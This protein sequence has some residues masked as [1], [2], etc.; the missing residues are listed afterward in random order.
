[1]ETVFSH[2]GRHWFWF[3]PRPRGL[4]EGWHPPYLGPQRG[5]PSPTHSLAHR[6]RAESI[7][8]RVPQR[9]PVGVEWVPKAHHRPASPRALPPLPSRHFS[10]WDGHPAYPRVAAEHPEHTLCSDS[11]GPMSSHSLSE[12]LSPPQSGSNLSKGMD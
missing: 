3:W 5:Q 10:L 6:T 7:L 11:Q 1:M 4:E 2:S 9:S 12:L 8:E